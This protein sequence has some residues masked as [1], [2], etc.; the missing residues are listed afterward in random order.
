MKILFVYPN[1]VESPKDISAGLAILSAIC[2]KNGHR[3]DL[4]DSSFG[5]TDQEIV[6]KTKKFSPD[7]VVITT[8]TN[9]FSYA[10]HIATLIKKNFKVPIIAGGYHPTTAPEE[11]ISKKCFDM[12]CIGEGEGALLDLIK[13]IEK[14]K[15]AE[16]IK[17][18]WIRKQKN[19]KTEIIKNPVRPL[20]EN[21][22]K[23]PFPDREIFDYKRYLKWN[24]GTA[25]F[26]ST[27]GCPF[28]CSFC[29][30]NL[31]IRLYKGKGCYIRFRSIDSLFQEIKQV[32]KRYG[33]IIKNL[34][35]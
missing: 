31:L 27:R 5:I 7:L 34:E 19:G 35:F 29:I 21:L 26:I 20:I 23:L 10:V 8:A 15:S 25:T 17:N 12:I 30:N 32:V 2:K 28:N 9:D 3:V 33:Y 13:A 1:I 24:H 14:G 16:K 11:A 4:I 22:D 18:L 6:K